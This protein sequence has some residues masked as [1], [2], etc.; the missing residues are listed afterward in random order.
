MISF[1]R[2]KHKRRVR[3]PLQRR[4]RRSAIAIDQMAQYHSYYGVKCLGE[5]EEATEFLEN[6]QRRESVI[7]SI[8]LPITIPSGITA[9][10]ANGLK[11]GV[12]RK[13][14]VIFLTYYFFG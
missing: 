11:R 4:K 1:I 3:F 7:S 8:L 5:N 10:Q 2:G 12:A 6:V 14:T 9:N 13:M